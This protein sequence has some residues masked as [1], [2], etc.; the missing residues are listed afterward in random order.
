MEKIIEIDEKT[1]IKIVKDNFMLEY[2]KKS[3]NKRTAWHTDG[4]FPDLTSLSIEYLNSSPYRSIQATEDFK[5]LIEILKEAEH[6]LRNLIINNK[7]YGNQ[8]KTK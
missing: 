7:F 4:C 6:N 3:R 2:K 5:R 1:R 8:E